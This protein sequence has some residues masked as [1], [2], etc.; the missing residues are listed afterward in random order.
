LLA[1]SALRAEAF[2]ES[3]PGSRVERE[4]VS[5]IVSLS[6]AVPASVLSP[7]GRQ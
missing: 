5:L 3:A 4:I 6:A 7:A 2:F 1:R